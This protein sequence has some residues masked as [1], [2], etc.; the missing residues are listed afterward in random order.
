MEKWICSVCGYTHQ[1]DNPPDR[2]P[3][4]GAQKSE[5]YR[6]KTNHGCAFSIIFLILM[7][8]ALLYSLLG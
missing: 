6:D 4:C 3:Q 2:C 1:G 8:A 7:T 5:F